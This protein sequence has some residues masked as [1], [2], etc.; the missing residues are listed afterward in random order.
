MNNNGHPII[1]RVTTHGNAGCVEEEGNGEW[2]GGNGKNDRGENKI[3]NT[4]IGINQSTRPKSLI[5]RPIDI[6]QSVSF[7]KSREA[8]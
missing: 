7:G 4:L 3:V 6:A 2:G 5:S 8:I 1:D